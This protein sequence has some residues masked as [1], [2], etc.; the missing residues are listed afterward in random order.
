MEKM[1]EKLRQV[2]PITI[3]HI[4][5]DKPKKAKKGKTTPPPPPPKKEILPI[6]GTVNHFFY[7][8]DTDTT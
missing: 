6:K 8:C 7:A 4:W 1:L 2:L 3:H 5:K